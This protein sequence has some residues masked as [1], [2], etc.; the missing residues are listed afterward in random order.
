[1]S[2][3]PGAC[4]PHPRPH[5]C[6]LRSPL[7][8]DPTFCCNIPRPLGD[9]GGDTGTPPPARAAPPAGNPEF[10]SESSETPVLSSPLGTGLGCH[11]PESRELGGDGVSP[12]SPEHPSCFPPLLS[13]SPGC[14]P[15][16]HPRPGVPELGWGSSSSD[17][18]PTQ[19]PPGPFVPALGI[20]GV[21]TYRGAEITPGTTSTQGLRE[22]GSPTPRRSS[23]PGSDFGGVLWQERCGVGKGGHLDPRGALTGW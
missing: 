23:P 1:M 8:A 19:A 13:P 21:Q 9:G 5:S 10:R 3:Q 18:I 7:S 11:P 17:E 14:K 2:A 15:G 22:L 16:E 4:C 20:I 6:P 12:T